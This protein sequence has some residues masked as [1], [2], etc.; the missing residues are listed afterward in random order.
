MAYIS[1]LFQPAFSRSQTWLCCLGYGL[2][3]IP[4][5]GTSLFLPTVIRTLGTYSTVEVQLRSVPPYVVATAWS[6]FIAY[7]CYKTRRHG[8][9]IAFS[10]IFS[11]IGYIGFVA[12]TN[13]KFL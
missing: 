7:M 12:S 2:I 4:V 13:P 11:V 1:P 8:V 5:Q 6:I 10:L 3:N 9:W